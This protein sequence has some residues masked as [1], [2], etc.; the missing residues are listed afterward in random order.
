MY[1]HEIISDLIN[2]GNLSPDKRYSKSC[3]IVSELVRK[4]QQFFVGDIKELHNPFKSMDGKPLLSANKEY[5]RLPYNIITIMGTCFTDYNRM[6]NDE[7][8]V[9]KETTL[10]QE[11]VKDEL[12]DIFSISY[13]KRYNKWVLV[14]TFFIADL[15]KEETKVGLMSDE[16]IKWDKVKKS[17]EECGIN[18]QMAINTILLLNCKNIGVETI[19][20]PEKLNK[21][22]KRK[23]KLPLF[24]YKTLK[25]Q[26]PGKK[27][28][29][30]KNDPTGEHNRIH[31]CRG[32]FK[33]YTSDK[34]LFG[35]ITG[36][37]WWQ[38][39]VRGRN[40]EGIVFKDYELKL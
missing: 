33:E 9:T 28:A 30:I 1:A 26:I 34:P 40:N 35:K 2:N 36:L 14:P 23:G 39:H 12:W 15:K 29:S 4:S 37:W 31:F 3:F 32:H 19:K 8:L 18:A 16:Y 6:E 38:P 5:L 22:R 13:S 20:P 11:L 7:L 27:H 17:A 10:I 21:A 25:I 24:T